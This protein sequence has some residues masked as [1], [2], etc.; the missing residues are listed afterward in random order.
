MMWLK[1]QIVSFWCRGRSGDEEKGGKSGEE[2]MPY[3]IGR[4]IKINGP[5]TTTPITNEF[6]HSYGFG[7][8]IK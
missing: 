2:R 3:A 6:F 8:I 4:F 7:T 1:S 5:G